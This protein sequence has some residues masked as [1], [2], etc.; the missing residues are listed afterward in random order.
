MPCP[1]FHVN[2][3]A[4]PPVQCPIALRTIT[5]EGRSRSSKEEGRAVHKRGGTEYAVP[6][7]THVRARSA[8]T[9]S[10]RRP[11]QIRSIYCTFARYKTVEGEASAGSELAQQ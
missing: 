9:A 2:W 3:L 4:W 11:Y 8:S 5:E 6:A 10:L 1:G 7:V